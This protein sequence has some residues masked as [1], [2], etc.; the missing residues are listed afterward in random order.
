MRRHSSDFLKCTGAAAMTGKTHDGI[1]GLQCGDILADGCH[2]SC[3]IDT[4]Y[5]GPGLDHLTMIQILPVQWVQSDGDITDAYLVRPRGRMGAFRHGER[6]AFFGGHVLSYRLAAFVVGAHWCLICHGKRCNLGSGVS[7][8]TMLWARSTWSEF[9]A[10]AQ[11][12]PSAGQRKLKGN[13]IDPR[14]TLLVHLTGFI[15][16][17]KSISFLAGP[18]HDAPA[19]VPPVSHVGRR[20]PRLRLCGGGSAISLCGT[21][22]LTSPAVEG[23]T[24]QY[25]PG[26]HLGR[27]EV[28]KKDPNLAKISC[29]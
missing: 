6:A 14:V 25:L 12:K 4:K 22:C 3:R 21:L 16:S 5:L 2:N 27:A 8:W 17:R 10:L 1:P 29:P 24:T 13:A 23:D 9:A 28:I 7:M 18:E 15:S 19:G 20:R 26:S 11:W